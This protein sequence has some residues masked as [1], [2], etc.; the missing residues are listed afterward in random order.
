MVIITMDTKQTAII[1]AIIVMAAFAGVCMM[2]D[3]DAA[4]VQVTYHLGDATIPVTTAEDGTVVLYGPD[5]VEAF[6]TVPDGKSFVAWQTQADG[7]TIYQF[8]AI[9]AFSDATDLYPRLVDIPQ[10]VTFVVNGQE[11]TAAISDGRISAMPE[12]MDTSKE[13]YTFD[14]WLGSDGKTYTSETILTADVTAGMTFA[15]QY[16]P[17]YDVVWIVDGITIATGDTTDLKQPED[18]EKDNYS[19]VEWRDG[20]GVAYSEDYEFTGDTTFTA[21]FSPVMLAVTFVAGEQTVATVT[22][23]Y[24]ETV[25]MP[26]L[27][28]GYA[29]WDFDF[30]TPITEAV[31]IEAIAADPEPE[32]PDTG[33][34]TVTLMSG[35]SVYMTLSSDNLPA[36]I[37]PPTSEGMTFTGWMLQGGSVYVDPLHYTYTE[38]TV[39]VAMFE[40]VQVVEHTV[41]FVA[42]GETVGTV[43]VADGQTIPQGSVPACPEGMF[44]DYDAAMVIVADTT[45]YAQPETVT[46]TFVV[47]E[48]QIPI[49]T[50]TVE[51]GGQVDVSLLESYTFPAGY[52]GWDFDF[53]QA[54]T[55]DVVIHAKEIVVPPETKWT[56]DTNNVLILAIVIIALIIAFAILFY[57]R[58][59]D[60][61]P[62]Q[63]QRLAKK[64]KQTETT[65]TAE[66]VERKE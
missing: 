54:L 46:V 55:S 26:A 30:S 28:E 20:D 29:S 52:D 36:A 31:T 57:L 51:Y 41:T 18:P 16:S 2:D 42:N 13:G 24:G 12:G 58:Q 66:T 63:L 40:A 60:R 5:D 6:Y 10:T 38:D 23:P 62:K 27:P 4:S 65:E 37:V 56:D 43:T 59:E 8:G 45:I 25:V 53:S 48:Q 3:S 64:P 22:V 61:L 39:F 21:Q 47:G 33:V 49:L 19:F 14:G 34:Y 1:A 32:D 35:G 50:Q 9:V 7:G 11:Y 17:I 44:W 15:A